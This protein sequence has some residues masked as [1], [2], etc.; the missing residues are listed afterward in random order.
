MRSG[1]TLYQVA[2]RYGLT[3]AT[4][5]SANKLVSADRI[6]VGTVLAI[7]AGP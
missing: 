7:P 5:V 4:L 6:A 2:K 1:E 3:V